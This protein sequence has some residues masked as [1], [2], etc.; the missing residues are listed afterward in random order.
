[1]SELTQCNYCHYQQ[2]LAE[3]KKKNM[4][5]TLL[6][7]DFGLG[8]VSVYMHP[9]DFDIKKASKKAR[10]WWSTGTWFMEISKHCCC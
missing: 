7:N 5:I 1:M 3:A 4:K 8:G 6:P 9:K 10:A 2:Y